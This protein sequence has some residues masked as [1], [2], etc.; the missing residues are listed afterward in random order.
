MQQQ[1]LEQPGEW[2]RL[3]LP[4]FLLLLGPT[5]GHR[6]VPNMAVSYARCCSAWTVLLSCHWQQLQAKSLAQSVSLLV[7]AATEAECE[8]PSGLTQ[9]DMLR[10]GYEG[11]DFC[12]PPSI[13]LLW[14]ADV[15]DHKNVFK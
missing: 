8:K 11:G 9:A 5:V 2:L 3:S 12:L 13:L 6:T 14:V 1:Q 10:F 7:P 15:C 4:P